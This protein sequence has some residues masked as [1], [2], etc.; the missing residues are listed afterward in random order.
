MRRIDEPE[1]SGDRT[2]L[3]RREKARKRALGLCTDLTDDELDQLLAPVPSFRT[4]LRSSRL[5][6][7]G[8][9]R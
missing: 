2:E 5:F 9:S 7:E 6:A 8:R 1:S 3:L 4:R